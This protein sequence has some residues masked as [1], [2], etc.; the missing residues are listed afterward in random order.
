MI[1]VYEALQHIR[2]EEESSVMK[3]AVRSE[4]KLTLEFG[5]RPEWSPPKMDKEMGRLYQ[6][7]MALLPDSSR[8]I[9]QF[10]SSRTEEGNSTIVGE[11]GRVLVQTIKKPVLLV[12]VGPSRVDQHRMFG[13]L[14]GV[15]LQHIMADGGALDPAI[16]QVKDSLLFVA[17]L[18]GERGFHTTSNFSEMAKDLWAQLCKQFPFILLDCPPLN[19]SE[20]AMG[21]CASVD[22]IVIVLEAEKTNFQVVSNL[23]DRIAQSGGSIL[24]VVFNKQRYYIPE[25]MYKHF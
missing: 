19:V 16:V 25:W 8:H 17:R 5:K 6:S 15:P 24:G 23:K 7:L 21:L 13:V 22:G 18:F 11:F 20:E 4:E 10:M 2:E 3:G 1:K 14:P 9:I 12:D